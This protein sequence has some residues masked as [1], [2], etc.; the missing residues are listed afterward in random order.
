[1]SDYFFAVTSALSDFLPFSLSPFF[2]F[3]FFKQHTYTII[4]MACYMKA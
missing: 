4:F 2:L 3:M 1:M